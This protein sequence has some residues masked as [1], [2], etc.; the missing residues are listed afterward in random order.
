VEPV[1]I[2]RVTY[3][4]KTATTTPTATFPSS[5]EP[6]SPLSLLFADLDGELATTRRMLE[7]VPN[8]HDDWRPHQKS[9]TLGALA[10]HLAQLP[11]FGIMMLTQDDFDGKTQRPE[12]PKL[13]S[14]AERVK[15]FDELSAQLKAI[16]RQLTWDKARSTW[17]LRMGDNVL[18]ETPR[19]NVFRSAF[20]THSAHHRAQVGVYLRLLDVPV[21]YSYGASAD[22]QPPMPPQ[23]GR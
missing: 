21:P 10:T 7:R 4:I 14:S 13:A 6:E 2:Q 12:E 20:I 9:R 22:E 1:N 19:V 17:T 15:M 16:L 11:G 5:V 23:A 8:G 18:L 3:K